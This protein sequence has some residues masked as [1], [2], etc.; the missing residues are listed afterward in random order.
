MLEHVIDLDRTF[1]A[2]ADK[3]RRSMV[4]RLTSGPASV[5]ELAEPL[6]MSLA[7]VVQHVQVLEACGVVRTEKVGRTRMCRIEPAA[8]TAAEQWITDRRRSW[9]ARLD[10]LGDLLHDR[11]ATEEEL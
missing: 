4:E 10:R 2:L 1:Q 5:S 9:E 8:M 3:S 7:A 11:A 6:A